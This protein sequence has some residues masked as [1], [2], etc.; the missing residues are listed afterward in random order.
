MF[1]ARIGARGGYGIP[2]A[3]VRADLARAK[4]AGLDRLLRLTI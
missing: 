3:P 1:A 4:Q 2:A